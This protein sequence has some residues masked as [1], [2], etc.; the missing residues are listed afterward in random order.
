MCEVNKFDCIRAEK[1][2]ALTTNTC[3]EIQNS[4][5]YTNPKIITVVEFVMYGQL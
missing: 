2:R 4:G 1:L 3:R 5:N